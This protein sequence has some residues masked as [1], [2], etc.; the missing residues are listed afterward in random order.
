ML[1]D[2]AERSIATMSEMLRTEILAAALRFLAVF[3][4]P[5][6][7]NWKTFSLARRSEVITYGIESGDLQARGI[8]LTSKGLQFDIVSRRDRASIS[9]ALVG[10]VNFY[11]ILA[12]AAAAQ[13]RGCSLAQIAHAVLNVKHVPGR[14]QRI[15]NGQPFTVVVDYA[16]TD[17]AL[18]NLTTLAREFV[19]ESKGR[20]ITVFGC[21]G[22]RDRSKRPLMG[23]A[24]GENSDFVLLTSDNPRSEDPFQIMHEVMPG[25]RATGV[26]YSLEPDRERAIRLAI[27]LAQKN[28][29][30]LIAGKGHEK[31]QVTRTGS[32]PFDDVEVAHK[33]L[34]AAGYTEDFSRALSSP[35]RSAT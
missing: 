14:F 30:V 15:D 8:N 10:R 21:G 27:R 25:L 7:P 19:G 22:D 5:L 4:I 2:S 31:V 35:G 13:A 11:N 23:R 12:A 17:D 28:D 34:Y 33:A 1:Y 29:I 26:E 24:A 32:K 16:H 18:R 9:S 3:W 6:Q 20:V